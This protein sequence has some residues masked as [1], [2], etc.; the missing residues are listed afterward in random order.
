LAE[1]CAERF[2]RFTDYARA[3]EAGG[4]FDVIPYRRGQV[5]VVGAE[6]PVD[7]VRWLRTLPDRRD[8]LLAIE[9][10]DVHAEPAI[11]EYIRHLPAS[12]WRDLKIQVYIPDEDMVLLH[13]ATR[14]EWMS[15]VG[16]HDLATIGQGFAWR[17]PSGAYALYQA[18]VRFDHPSGGAGLE[19]CWLRPVGRS[20][21][22]S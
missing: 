3:L 4:W 9:A 18:S 13:A 5:I 11:A 16:P 1:F 17:I 14:G 21:S 10:I 2:R 12:A 8:Y 7:A 6:A 20:S 22:S 19:A 15:E